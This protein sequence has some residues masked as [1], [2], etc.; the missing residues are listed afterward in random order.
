MS[1]SSLIPDTSSE[2]SSKSDISETTQ[3]AVSGSVISPATSLESASELKPKSTNYEEHGDSALTDTNEEQVT[4][5]VD[6]KP[7]TNV[8]EDSSRKKLVAKHDSDDEDA[9]TLY[10]D[11]K[12][13]MFDRRY[14]EAI[15]SEKLS[16]ARK[17]APT[18]VLQYQQYIGSMEDRIKYL[19][20][21]LVDVRQLVDSSTKR[22]YDTDDSEDEEGHDDG[23]H[24]DAGDADQKTASTEPKE[25]GPKCECRALSYKDY[26]RG[27]HVKSYVVSTL[28]EVEEPYNRTTVSGQTKDIVV[29]QGGLSNRISRL[30]ISSTPIIEFLDQHLPKGAAPSSH[31]CIILRPFKPL[32][33]LETK[34]REH[35]ARLETEL[36]RREKEKSEKDPLS[37]V[38]EEVPDLIDFNTYA[39]SVQNGDELEQS[40]FDR[41]LGS[42]TTARNHFRTLIEL[43]DSDLKEVLE[44]HKLYRR[45]DAGM[46]SQIR[47]EDLWHLF[48]PGQVVYAEQPN[49]Q[50]FIILN[51]RGGRRLHRRMTEQVP[52]AEDPEKRTTVRIENKSHSN[53]YMD[54]VHIDFDGTDLGFLG[55]VLEIPYYKGERDIASLPVVPVDLADKKGGTSC[56]EY[57]QN[58]GRKFLMLTREGTEIGYAHRDYT[59]TSLQD[60]DPDTQKFTSREQV[61]QTVLPYTP[62]KLM[63]GR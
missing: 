17:Q 58:R 44:S 4:A 21:E 5:I 47:F 29:D 9:D 2:G 3:S 43:M 18:R 49:C 8:A 11:V 40:I 13:A 39:E 32:C 45:L 35:L 46:P 33:Q 51:V 20:A 16:K 34:I 63:K 14:D 42:V 31:T 38:G 53:F 59:G 36:E 25:A 41:S 62:L 10:W 61:S 19:E 55:Q 57:L 23:E 56:R 22:H 12:S 27:K 1:S 50:A 37:K 6:D 15:D 30:C 7:A 26:A 54:C 28:S 52:I 48:V 24:A 60:I